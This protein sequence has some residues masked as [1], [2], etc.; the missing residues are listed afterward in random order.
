MWLKLFAIISTEFESTIDP[1]LQHDQLAADRRSFL[2]LGFRL[3]TPEQF[4]SLEPLG[5]QQTT[6][7]R[8]LLGRSIGCP[9][10]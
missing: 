8:S 4:L 6:C 2:W 5:P 9:T 7:T 3:L 10:F 1:L